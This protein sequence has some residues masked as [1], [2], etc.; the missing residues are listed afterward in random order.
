MPTDLYGNKV[1]HCNDCGGSFIEDFNEG[2]GM[3]DKCYAYENSVEQIEQAAI[4]A[5]LLAEEEA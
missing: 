5:G 3:C 2:A 4:D 1:Y